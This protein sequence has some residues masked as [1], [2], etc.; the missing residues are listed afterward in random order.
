MKT[1]RTINFVLALFLILSFFSPSTAYAKSATEPAQPATV[2]MTSLTVNN[3]TGGTLYIQMV[4]ENY[5]SFSTAAAG[6]TTF[7]NI[8]SGRYT[9]TLT[10]SACSGSLVYKNRLVKNRFNIKPV[11]CNK[12]R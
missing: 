10:T 8:K 9:I 1:V 5:Y 4:G 2:K 11:G 7:W 12:R 3:R 6:K